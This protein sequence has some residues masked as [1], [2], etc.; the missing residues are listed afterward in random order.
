MLWLRSLDTLFSREVDVS[1]ETQVDH[2]STTIGV[3]VKIPKDL[4][5]LRREQ[6][7]SSPEDEISVG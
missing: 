3:P 1:P 4:Q 6:G 2:D 5:E 7:T